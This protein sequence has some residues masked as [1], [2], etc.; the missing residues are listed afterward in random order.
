VLWALSS[1]YFS[2]NRACHPVPNAFAIDDR[3]LF[4]RQFVGIEVLRE[5]AAVLFEQFLAKGFDICWFDSH[6]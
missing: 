2:C 1:I 4:N 5:P 6:L 3:D